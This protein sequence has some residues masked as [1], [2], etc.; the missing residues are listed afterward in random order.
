[1]VGVI[2]WMIF[3]GA[4][5][6]PA[7][8]P[9]RRWSVGW[10]RFNLTVWGSCA[11]H[12]RTPL[13]SRQ[14]RNTAIYSPS[15][16]ICTRCGPPCTALIQYISV[17]IDFR[18]LLWI[19][20]KICSRDL[21]PKYMMKKLFGLSSWIKEKIANARLGTLFFWT[22]EYSGAFPRLLF[23]R[24]PGLKLFLRKTPY[25]LPYARHRITKPPVAS[26]V[27]Y[28]PATLP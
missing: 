7:R 25:T 22:G 24:L 15:L 1:M 27:S 4:R 11:T 6:L 23:S 9:L 26:F 21:L 16:R 28:F 13:P 17:P 19:F 14:D 2:C 20:S 12:G 3:L 18:F 5:K 10:K 8:S